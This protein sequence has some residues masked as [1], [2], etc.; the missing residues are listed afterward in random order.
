MLLTKAYNIF[1]LTNIKA[2]LSLFII[3]MVFAIF[4]SPYTHFPHFDVEVFR[5]VG[6]C[7]TK[8]YVPYKDAFDHKPPLIYFIKNF[9]KPYPSLKQHNW[10]VFGSLTQHTQG[11]FA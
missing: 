2:F 10:C 8:G 1:F 7:I 3:C 9:I 6:M 11:F 5:Y 4:N